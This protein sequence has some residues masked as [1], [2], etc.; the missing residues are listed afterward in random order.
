MLFRDFGDTDER[1]EKA[2]RS[3]D[4]AER[5]GWPEVAEMIR[6]QGVLPDRCFDDPVAYADEVR[7]R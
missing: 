5:A 3:Y 1:I 6:Y 2:I 4:L 7:A